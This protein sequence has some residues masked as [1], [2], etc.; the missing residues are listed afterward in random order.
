M[1]TDYRMS[2]WKLRDQVRRLLTNIKANDKLVSRE[3]D[4]KYL[5]SGYILKTEIKDL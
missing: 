2:G 1:E 5:D 3:S 4:E